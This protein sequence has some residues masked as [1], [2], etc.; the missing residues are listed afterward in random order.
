MLK[1]QATQ[2][3]SFVAGLFMEV[4]KDWEEVKN[5]HSKLDIKQKRSGDATWKIIGFWD[6]WSDEEQSASAY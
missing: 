5:A 2:R 6:D 3:A 4:D 1:K